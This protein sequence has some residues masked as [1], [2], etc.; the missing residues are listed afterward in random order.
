MKR[1]NMHYFI[2]TPQYGRFFNEYRLFSL[3][4]C[5]Y[6]IIADTLHWFFLREKYVIVNLSLA[7]DLAVYI[8]LEGL[9]EYHISSQLFFVNYNA[10]LFN[11][12]VQINI[13]TGGLV[14]FFIIGTIVTVDGVCSCTSVGIF[15]FNNVHTSST[16]NIHCDRLTVKPYNV[17][18]DNGTCT[19][20]CAGSRHL[21]N[22][23]LDRCINCCKCCCHG[24]NDVPTVP[25]HAVI[26]NCT[27]P[28]KTTGT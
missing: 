6:R 9:L 28:T 18:P 16:G 7:I 4:D 15:D 12:M 23:D 22:P 20:Y 3:S 10:Q 2:F 8:H 19:G 25:Y 26:G 5:E 1:K 13:Y 14:L 21:T 11:N 17:K 24:I 27:L